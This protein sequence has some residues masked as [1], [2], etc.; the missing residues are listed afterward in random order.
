MGRPTYSIINTNVQDDV[1]KILERILDS[2]WEEAVE[3]FAA[4]TN[5]DLSGSDGRGGSMYYKRTDVKSANFN[6]KI[7]KMAQQAAKL[8]NDTAYSWV[9]EYDDD[10]ELEPMEPDP[11]FADDIIVALL[12]NTTPYFNADNYWTGYDFMFDDNLDDIL[13]DIFDDWYNM[14]AHLE[15]A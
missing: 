2:D 6:K 15:W 11:I 8:L 13:E 14:E 5:A 4:N 3:H 9:S 12:D 10:D 1:E 7:W